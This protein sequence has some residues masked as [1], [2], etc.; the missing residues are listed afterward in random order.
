MSSSDGEKIQLENPIN[1][2]NKELKPRG[3]E[4]WLRE[5]E[6]SMKSTL[7]DLLNKTLADFI[8]IKRREWLFNWPS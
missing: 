5:V 6:K 3:V 2:L 7:F 4:E 1:P 8:K